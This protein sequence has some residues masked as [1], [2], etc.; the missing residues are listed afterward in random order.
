[1]LKSIKYWPVL[2]TLGLLSTSAAAE[3]IEEDFQTWGV[4]VATG[5]F[6]AI[7][8]DWK[9]FKYWVEGQGRFGNDTSR[10]SQGMVRNGLGYA[11]NDKT[12]VWLGHAWVPTSLPFA[13]RKAFDEHRIWQQLL[14][15]DKFSFGTL[16]S[17]TRLEQRFFSGLPRS[18]DT[19]YRFR[20][21]IK[22][23]I[24]LPSISPAFGLAFYDE[25]FINLN[26][27]D[28]GLRDGFALNRG[29]AGVFY[30]LNQHTVFEIGYLNQFI[31]TKKNPRSDLMQHILAVQ[32][33]MNF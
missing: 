28:S 16:T 29:F 12:S 18:E 22:L 19:G 27:T 7:N 9:N 31:N 5:S 1:M 30:R 25:L 6:G 32:L 20:Q 21:F 17:R 33:F 14:W 3:N 4:F 8:P 2:A 13:A 10:F 23:S 26:N 24:P 11:V 15:S